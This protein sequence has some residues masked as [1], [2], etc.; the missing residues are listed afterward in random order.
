MA[1]ALPPKETY[2]W[3]EIYFITQSLEKLYQNSIVNM[4]NICTHGPYL[5]KNIALLCYDTIIHCTN[6]LN[7]LIKLEPTTTY[8]PYLVKNIALALR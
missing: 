6:I 8:G 3:Y 5:V 2:L 4:S 1:A 7:L